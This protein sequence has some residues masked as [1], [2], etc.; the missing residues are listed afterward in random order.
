MTGGGGR[1]EAER[2][3][4][5]ASR[6]RPVVFEQEEDDDKQQRPRDHVCG[7]DV[8]RFGEQVARM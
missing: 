4:S 3:A 2:S 7:E 1:H 5:R 8:E 6:L